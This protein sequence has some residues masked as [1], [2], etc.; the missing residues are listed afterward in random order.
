L[1]IIRAPPNRKTFSHPQTIKSILYRPIFTGQKIALNGIGE[2]FTLAHIRLPTS[3]KRRLLFEK[4]KPPL[5]N[6]K[7]GQ[8]LA[9]SSFNLFP[10]SAWERDFRALRVQLVC[11]KWL[12]KPQAV[13]I[14]PHLTAVCTQNEATLPS[15]GIFWNNLPE[16]IHS[17]LF[18]TECQGGSGEI[19]QIELY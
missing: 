1:S 8:F 16:S 19:G 3:D 7:A 9:F 15:T 14:T 5:P 2:K 13:L 12:A 6:G 11:N 4:T 17:G 18:P 10:C